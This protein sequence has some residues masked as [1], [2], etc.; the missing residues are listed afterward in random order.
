MV[1]VDAISRAK[2]VPI[3]SIATHLK[4]KRQG[5]EWVGSCPAC[6][7]TDRFA[8]HLT[9]Q[10]F[11]CRGC[12]ARGDVIELLRLIQGCSFAD[13]VAQLAGGIVRSRPRPQAPPASARMIDDDDRRKLAMA[14]TI[15]NESVPIVGTPGADY[16][17]GRG[18]LLDLVP[19][20]G[21][22]RFHSACPWKAGTAA[23]VIGRFTTIIGNEPRGIWRR[24]VAGGHKPM[25]LGASAGCVLRLWP[26]EYVAE[27]LVIGEGIETTLVAATRIEHRS[28]ML[29]PAWACGSAGTLEFFPVLAS[30]E[31]LTIL[32]DCDANFAGQDAARICAERW[33]DA[34][35]EAM[36]LT[37]R[38]LGTDFDD[39][40][41]GAP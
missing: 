31:A 10:V 18:I 11:N 35:R 12:G 40:I 7:G 16:L 21:G 1:D 15:W 13:A 20:H 8:I 38:D 33:A 23:A 19:D 37:P 2:A 9:K 22:M 41:R 24:P 28:T 6:G 17:A 30:I 3:Q 26:D 36:I 5:K 29:Q 4:L 27:G 25:S 32:A 34:G 39:L 14:A